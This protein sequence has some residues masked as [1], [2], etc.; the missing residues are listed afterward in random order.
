METR[1]VQ[2]SG[3]TTYTVSL[4][5]SWAREHGIEAGSVLHLHPD[6]D[7]TLLVESVEDRA[8]DRRTIR[9]DVTRYSEEALWETVQAAYL[10]GAD[11]VVLRDRSGDLTSRESAIGSA[12]ADLSG[13][14][15][16]E[17]TDRSLTLRSLIDA[18]QISIRKSLLRLKLITLAMHR[19]AVS[20]AL[21]GDAELAG[22]VVDRDDEVDKLFALVT[23]HF[24]RSVDDLQEVARLG[25][26][27][28]DLFE[29]YY[30]ARQLERVADHTVKMARLVDHREEPPEGAVRDGVSTTADTASRIVEN[31]ADVVLSD[32]DVSV[33]HDTLTRCN[34]LVA[35]I[36]DLDRTLYDLEADAD[37]FTIG[38]L[39][40]SIGRT[41]EYGRN[42][43]EV[44]IQ[45]TV[46]ESVGP[47]S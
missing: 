47:S 35:E 45:R 33:A 25:E 4:P 14:E 30:V 2:L 34:E 19:D 27:R 1:K 9:F 12:V 17:S 40:D 37:A 36:D 39:L 15:V 10:V 29:Y 13:F 38:L 5:K 41:A 44:A 6:E 21:A 43:A 18:E 8:S 28:S 46:R 22:Q 3:G 20:A 16:V 32:A 23:R 7:G 31:A 24:R 42:V 11:E 26:T